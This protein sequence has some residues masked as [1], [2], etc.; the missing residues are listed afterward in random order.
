MLIIKCF[1]LI[2]QPP[3]RD[4]NFMLRDANFMLR[5]VETSKFYKKAVHCNDYII[6]Y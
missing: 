1:L 2:I 3:I 5:Q 4:A 6:Y